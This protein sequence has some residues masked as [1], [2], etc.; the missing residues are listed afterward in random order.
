MDNPAF[1]EEVAE[2]DVD[3]V[4]QVEY[5]SA[6][7]PP[8]KRDIGATI[9]DIPEAVIRWV[10]RRNRASMS[11]TMTMMTMTMTAAAQVEHRRA[12]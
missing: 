10:G 12:G 3:G 11:R 8:A 6:G 7:K 5:F 9:G 1:A 4:P 2:F